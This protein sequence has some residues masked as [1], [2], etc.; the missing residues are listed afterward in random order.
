MSLALDYGLDLEAQPNGDYIC[1]CPF[2]NDVETK[3][4]RIYVK[5]N[6]FH[7]FGCQTGSSIFEFVMGMEDIEFKEALYRLAARAG[8]SDHFE[9]RD[10]NIKQEDDN[11]TT[12]REYIETKAV[13]AAREV[14]AEC[15]LN[16]RPLK[17]IYKAFEEL[18]KWYDKNQIIFN[19]KLI[20]G[21]YSQDL[22]VKLY[23][24]YEIF[25]QK[26]GIIKNTLT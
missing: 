9:L 2:H 14:Y 26:L 21:N 3:S 17:E 5:S 6:T 22:S 12:I 13:K 4:M 16:Q 24:F 20:K 19:K 1:L 10:L 8:Y 18:W 11:F 15:L 7:C 25:L 23:K